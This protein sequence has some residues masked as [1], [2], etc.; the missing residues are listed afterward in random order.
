MAVCKSLR[1]T[2]VA[3]SLSP[4]LLIVHVPEG[5]SVICHATPFNVGTNDVFNVTPEIALT[6]S[7]A[8]T[9][10]FASAFATA[11]ASAIL[12]VTLFKAT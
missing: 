7:A 4:G 9:S 8:L 12:N 1:L 10:I 3:G 2:T 11:P 6:P 5:V